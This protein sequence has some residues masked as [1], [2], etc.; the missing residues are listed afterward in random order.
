MNFEN[1]LFLY[2]IIIFSAI[3]H[4]Y[5]HGWTAYKLGDPTA[6]FAGR[7]TLN[8]LAHIDL[9]GTVL[10]PLILMSFTGIFFGYAKPVPFNPYNLK[11]RYGP[12]LVALAGPLSNFLIALVF[13]LSLRLMPFNSL[14]LLFPLI[15]MVNIWLA[16]FNLLP[17][18]PLDGSKIIALILPYKLQRQTLFLETFSFSGIFLA[19]ILAWFV[20]PRLA[21]LLYQLIVGAPL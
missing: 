15:V 9:V 10:M 5:A 13:G 16:L 19:L 20:I 12:S 1:A 17:F 4:E 11:T 3:V 2:L 6:K 18:P 7:L 8:P 14:I 21:P